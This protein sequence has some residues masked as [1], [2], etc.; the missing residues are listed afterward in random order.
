MVIT[1]QP[2]HLLRVKYVRGVRMKKEKE[3][4]SAQA[5]IVIVLTS[6]SED[7]PIIISEPLFE[8]ETCI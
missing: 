7:H 2:T 3:K 8:L 4:S 1:S 5:P 6:G